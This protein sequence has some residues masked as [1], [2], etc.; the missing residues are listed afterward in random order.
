MNKTEKEC[1]NCGETKNLSK[2]HRAGKERD[3][4]TSRCGAC[5]NAKSKE[6]RDRLKEKNMLMA[7]AKPE[8]KIVKVPVLIIPKGRILCEKNG[9]IITEAN[10][11]QGCNDACRTCKSIQTANKRTINNLSPEEEKEGKYSVTY[12]S[13][14]AIA[15]EDGY[16]DI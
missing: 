2:F 15:V 6:A 12:R 13:S 14:A 16:R 1:P 8:I 3:G 9:N 10:C 7:K 5:I 4:R 11:I